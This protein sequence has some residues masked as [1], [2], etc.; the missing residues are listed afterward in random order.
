MEVVFL[1][2]N[3][4]FSAA[5]RPDAGLS[6]LWDLPDVELVSSDYALEEARRNLEMPDQRE[7]LSNFAAE[8]RLVTTISDVDLPEGVEVPDKDKPIL[9]AAISAGATHLLTGDFTHFGEL[10]GSSIGGGLILPPSEYLRR[11]GSGPQ[12]NP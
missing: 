4:L 3:V 8:L 1:D 10:Y 12:Q 7:R 9:I 11:Y 6:R 2:A 5:Y